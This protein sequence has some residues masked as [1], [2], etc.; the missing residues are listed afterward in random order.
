MKEVIIDTLID[1]LKLLPFLFI[2]FLI[3]ELLE[4]S[5]SKKSKIIISKSGNPITGSLLGVVPQCGFS[6]VAT[7]LYI[8]RV[9]S[10]GTLISIYLSTSDEML[11]ILISTKAPFNTIIS[12]LLIKIFIG[13]FVGIIIDL[14]YKNVKNEDYHI[15]DDDSCHCEKGIFKSSIIHTFKVLLF[16]LIVSLCLNIVFSYYSIDFLNDK[17]YTPF[18]SSII[19]LIPN[20]ASSVALTELYLSGAIT[21]GSMIAGLLSNSGVALLLLFKENKNIKENISILT[22]IYIVGVVSGL[23]INFMC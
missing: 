2:S 6:C 23:I 16:I 19:G 5:F 8:T 7:N 4:H 21:T 15:C 18:I 3:I 20:C 10:L 13:M 14:I 22:I 12:I 11:P 17:F 1:G 9:I